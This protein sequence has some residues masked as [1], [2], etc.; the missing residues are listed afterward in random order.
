MISIIDGQGQNHARSLFTEDAVNPPRTGNLLR[1][2]KVYA[3]KRRNSN[4]EIM[5]MGKKVTSELSV[6]CVQEKY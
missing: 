1:I 5:S 4:S 3:W 2:A 6:V